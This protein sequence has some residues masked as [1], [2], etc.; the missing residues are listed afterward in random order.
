MDR[1]K[2]AF[3][4]AFSLEGAIDALVWLGPTAIVG[5][6][7]RELANMSWLAALLLGAGVGSLSLALYLDRVV[8]PRRERETEEQDSVRPR[9][10]QFLRAW[11][12]QGDYLELGFSNPTQ[13]AADRFAWENNVRSIL[14]DALG[15]EAPK[16]I[17]KGEKASMIGIRAE[18][19]RKLADQLDDW[20]LR[21]FDLKYLPKP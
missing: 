1:L 11:A 21:D 14:I 2:R 10:K 12:D 5:A 17:F 15:P 16:R 3:R 8:R 7:L 13:L 4:A 20:E 19:L 9:L 6:L 18:R